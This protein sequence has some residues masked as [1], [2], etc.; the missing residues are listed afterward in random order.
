M[1]ESKQK[2][3]VY[4]VTQQDGA[5]VALVRAVSKAAAV[6]HAVKR[7]FRADVATQDELIDLVGAGWRVDVAGA[8]DPPEET[9]DDD[10]LGLPLHGQPAKDTEID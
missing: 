10:Q 7:D 2:T 3:R 9:G 6:N 8:E 4:V 5:P 1:N